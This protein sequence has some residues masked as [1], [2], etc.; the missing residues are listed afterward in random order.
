MNKIKLP[1]HILVLDT[2]GVI[3]AGV[4]LYEWFSGSSLIPEQYHFENYYLVMV[5]IGLLLMAPALLYII[6]I[7][8]G[9]DKN[10]GP[11]EI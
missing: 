8:R 1:I 2:I 10:S 7:A 4:G 9:G 5:V 6:K 3:L 11:R